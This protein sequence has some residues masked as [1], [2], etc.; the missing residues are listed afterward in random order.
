M[1]QGPIARLAPECPLRGRSPPGNAKPWLTGDRSFQ[2]PGRASQ[3]KGKGAV[4]SPP[5]W[6]PLVGVDNLLKVW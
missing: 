4:V 1:D 2:V 6:N 3:G 5:P